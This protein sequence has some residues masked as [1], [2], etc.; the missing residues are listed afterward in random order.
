MGHMA[1]A[2]TV[3]ISHLLD[4]VRKPAQYLGGEHNARNKPWDATATKF[5][6]CFPDAYEVGMS[7]LAID[8]LYELVNDRT[9]HLCDRAFVPWPDLADLMRAEG[10]ALFGWETRRPL[11]DFDIV[12]FSMSYECDHTNVLEALDLAGIPLESDERGEDDPIVLA[13]GSAVANPEPMADFFDLIA[14]GEGEELLVRLLDAYAGFD[15]GRA[16][17]RREFL[18]HCARTIPGIYAPSLYRP[19]YH[20]DDTLRGYLRLA[21]GIPERIERQYVDI[22]QHS[23]SE[24]PLVPL[25]E[26]V[27]DRVAI[28]LDRGCARAC[29]FCQ[30]G[31]LYRPVRRRGSET[32]KQAAASCLEST[33]QS[34]LS[35]LSLNAADYR[36]LENV[37]TDIFDSRPGYLRVSIPSTRVESFNVD[38]ARALRRGGKRGGSLTFAP[39]AATPRMRRVINKT[40]SDAALLET[41]DMAFGEG[42]RTIKL[43]FMIGQPTETLDDARAIAHL[44]NRVM[45]LGRRRHGKKATLNV[46]VSTFVPK[47][48]TPFQWHPQDRTQAIRAK[49]RACLAGLRDRNIHLMWRNPE[50]SHV[51]A[52]LA[53]G[54]RRVGR[55]IRRAW[56]KGCRFDGWSEHFKPDAWFQAIQDAGLDLDF[57]IHRHR[58][59]DE[60]LPWDHIQIYVP[61]GL[62]RRE[63]LRGLEAAKD[64]IGT[65]APLVPAKDLRA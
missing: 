37:I 55:A 31:Y 23:G 30:A 21:E 44:A 25:T 46:T 24:R 32:V 64:A 51:E 60:F 59:L 45:A 5:V 49:Q 20:D 50:E 28:E 41:C 3:D 13:G 11:R 9:R 65:P 58:G 61:K 53:L 62:L 63:Y 16:G 56:E 54:D 48:F 33:G 57:Y 8:L 15:R 38:L 4:R 43:Y 52:L 26:V 10:I 35:L 14:I 12:G 22:D 19:L 34:E 18:H 17:W 47:P 6:I 7:N 27:H 2:Q 29:R 36:G 42:F 39:E 40:I 1:V